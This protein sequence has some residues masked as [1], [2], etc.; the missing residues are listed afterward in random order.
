MMKTEEGRKDDVERGG[1]GVGN[2]IDRGHVGVVVDGV[3][4]MPAHVGRPRQYNK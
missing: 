3:V 2:G 1:H 4:K